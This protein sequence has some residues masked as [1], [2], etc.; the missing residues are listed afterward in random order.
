MTVYASTAAVKRPRELWAV[1]DAYRD[2]GINAVELGF[3]DLDDPSDL[4]AR[5]QRYDFEYLV[6]NYFP[7][8]AEAFVI[9]LASRDV[10][11]ARRSLELVLDALELT[12]EL[13]APFYSVHCGWITD[14][15][16]FDGTSFVLPDPAPG[17]A[18][19]ARSRFVA[20]LHTAVR[21]AEEL[22][23]GLLVETSVCP[24]AARGKLL[25]LEADDLAAMLAEL[26]SPAL[27]LLVDTGHLNVTAHTLGFDRLA[28]LQILARDVRAWHVHDNDGVVDQHLPARP[29]SWVWDTL[30]SQDVPRPVIVEAKFAHAA[31][32]AEHVDILARL[33][34]REP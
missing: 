26:A 18:A 22:G 4:V 14:P 19:E 24:P 10:D 20:A 23:L 6:H 31:A 17:E 8:P 27:G 30:A 9:N 25:L 5:L 21:R 34:E 1:L 3:A 16:G 2:A 32:L 29:G 11:L 28:F 13:G 15:V 33:V 7:P 12:A